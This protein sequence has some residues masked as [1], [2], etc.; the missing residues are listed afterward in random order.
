MTLDG[1]LV[2][3]ERLKAISYARAAVLLR[4]ELD[5]AEIVNAFQVVVELPRRQVAEGLLR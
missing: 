4:P 3:T 1:T 5:K 2:Q